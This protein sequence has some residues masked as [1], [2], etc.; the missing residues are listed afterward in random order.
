[1]LPLQQ[2]VPVLGNFILFFPG[3][4]QVA[5]VDVL[6]PDEHANHSGPRGLLDEVRK[7][8]AHGIHLDHKP[9]I[10]PRLL[11]QFDQAVENLFPIHIAREVVV[12]NEEAVHPL[13]HILADDLLHIVRRPPPRFAALHVDDGAERALKR[14][15]AAG[16]ET[17]EAAA[18]SP[19]LRRRKNGN[20]LPFQRR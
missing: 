20:G 18:G 6:E 8:V 15:S 13:R 9:D 2:H 12:R 17:G 4:N 11:A 1:M 16:I 5:G 7:P 19:D 10:Q 14:A 3:P